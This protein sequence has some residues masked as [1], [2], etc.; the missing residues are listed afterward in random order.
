MRQSRGGALTFG[1]LACALVDLARSD[2]FHLTAM[3][4]S[5]DAERLAHPHRQG[6]EGV[7]A[8]EKL[9]SVASTSL[10]LRIALWLSCRLKLLQPKRTADRAAKRREIIGIPRDQSSVPRS[11]HPCVLGLRPEFIR[12]E[13]EPA[14]RSFFF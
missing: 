11:T 12:S 8:P 1:C 2:V 10:H 14:H 6:V 13:C 5:A 4:S 7:G 3:L 9:P